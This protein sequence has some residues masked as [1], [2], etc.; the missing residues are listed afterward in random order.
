M[1]HDVSAELLRKHQSELEWRVLPLMRR[2]RREEVERGEL[3]IVECSDETLHPI[4]ARFVRPEVHSLMQVDRP[5]VSREQLNRV[6]LWV[7]QDLKELKGTHA[8]HY[9]TWGS[10]QT[11]ASR[12]SRAI[13]IPQRPGCQG[14]EKWYDLTGRLPGIGFWPMA[15]KYRH[16]IPWN[17]DRL[18]CNHN[19]FDI[20]PLTL[21]ELEQKALMGV[22]NSTI[23]GLFK[24]FYGRYAGS[25]GTLKTEIV[26]ALMMEVPNPLGARRGLCQRLAEALEAIGTREVTHLVEQEF[27]ECHTETRMRELQATHLQLPLEL[28][29]RDRRELDLL[30]FELLG[31]SEAN[32]RE[33]LV[34]RLYKETALYYRQQRIQDI[35][36]TI[37]RAKGRGESASQSE[38]ALDAWNHF[39]P[40]IQE[41]LPTWV[42]EE[43]G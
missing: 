42:E 39:D 6:V 12:K 17:P 43:N 21:N 29:R 25:E 7:N 31:V 26:D 24:H 1:P 18:P 5:V 4:E 33:D 2:C 30:T 37:N 40:E 3:V 15:Q 11:F 19:L 14:R 32:R 28:Q 13:P 23:V 9:I 20:H 36:S 22:L 8:W 27:L 35:Q 34:D 16:I 38:L 10:K 41:P